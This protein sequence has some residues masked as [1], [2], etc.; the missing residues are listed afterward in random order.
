MIAVVL[1]RPVVATDIAVGRSTNADSEETS[2]GNIAAHAT[3]GDTATRWCAADGGTGHWLHV[4]LG[5]AT[6]LTG[7][8]IAWELPGKTYRY[9]VEGSTDG[10]TWSTLVDR[11]NNSDTGQ[12]HTLPFI[13][14]VRHLRVTVTGLDTGCWASIREFEVYDRPFA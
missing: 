11:T 6:A 9:R 3:D 5:T 8:R 2:K 12:V 1:D 7:V 13:A 14:T 4:D 10:H